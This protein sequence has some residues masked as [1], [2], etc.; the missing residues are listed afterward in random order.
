MLCAGVLQRHLPTLCILGIVVLELALRSLLC[1]GDYRDFLG[2]ITPLGFGNVTGPVIFCLEQSTTH[3]KRSLLVMTR[4]LISCESF[5]A[6]ESQQGNGKK[7]IV[8]MQLSAL[9]V[10]LQLKGVNLR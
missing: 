7:M 1:Y 9:N 3:M 10:N 5:G 2:L 4:H 8:T 6:H